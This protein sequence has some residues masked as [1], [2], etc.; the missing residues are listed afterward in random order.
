MLDDKLA[1]GGIC[2]LRVGRC[3]EFVAHE[4]GE[5]LADGA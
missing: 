1:R 4:I 5:N 2:G 3:N